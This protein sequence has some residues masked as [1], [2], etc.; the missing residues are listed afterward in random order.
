MLFRSEILGGFGTALPRA[1]R[2]GVRA[3]VG[4]PSATSEKYA[5]AAED[6]GFKLSPAQVRQDIPVPAKGA[7]GWS[8]QNQSLANKL[9]S[10]ATGQEAKEISPEFL[11]ERLTDLGKQYDKLY[12]GKDFAVDANVVSALNNILVKEQELGVAG[13]STV[14]QA[15]IGR[16]H[17]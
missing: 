8:E 15:E 6:L 9:A 4:T 3:L 11:R 14:K 17:V 16:A 1:L 12:K 2:G 7:T 10:S 13:V 5:R